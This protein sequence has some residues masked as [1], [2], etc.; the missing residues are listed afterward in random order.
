MQAALRVAVVLA[1]SAVAV[2]TAGAKG[3]K[4]PSFDPK[5]V[6]AV[7][8]AV[9][10]AGGDDFWG[11]VLVASGGKVVY[12]KAFG[13]ADYE[14]KPMAVD[15][16][17]EIASASKQF[18]ATAILKLEQQ[19]KL[20]TSDT[21]DRFF[22][23]V[24]KDKK[25]VTVDHLIH[26]TSGMSNQIGMAYGW[27]GSRDEYV[28][29][30]L[31]HALLSEPGEKFLYCNAAY[32][33]LAAIVEVASKQTFEEYCRKELFA[34]AGMK[35]TGFI[36][37]RELVKTGRATTRRMKDGQP[38][39]TA[40][41]WMYGWGYRGM[42]GVV[43]TAHDLL[44]WDRALRGTKVLGDAAKKKLYAPE[45]ERY[46]CGWTVEP[47][48]RGGTK[49]SHGGSVGGYHTMIARWLDDDLVVVVLTNDA[50]NERAIEKAVADAY[51]EAS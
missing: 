3:E 21:I 13:F 29:V 27:P 11:T 22:P 23:K 19:K 34:P 28:D 45:L 31:S 35:D 30:M 2:R 12:A 20:K 41:N 5:V 40:A 4:A 33:I 16:L 47:G 36:N 26:H 46:A 38:N 17:F 18:T 37:D 51:R 42:G 24:G 32:A 25:K 49:V 43:S 48:D 15:S 10:R 6:A 39:W 1:A 9:G 7:D 8:G 44:A 50:E 14:K